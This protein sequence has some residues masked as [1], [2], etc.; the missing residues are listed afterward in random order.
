MV[1]KAKG[2]TLS[3]KTLQVL[4]LQALKDI[5]MENAEP[6]Q[7]KKDRNITRTKD[8]QILTQPYS[9]IVRK[10]LTKRKIINKVYSEPFGYVK[11]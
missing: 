2:I 1:V 7:I 6:L 11:K 5:V 3:Y 9:K 4:T 10:V 8:F